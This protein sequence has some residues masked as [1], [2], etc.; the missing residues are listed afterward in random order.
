MVEFV[1]VC[2]LIAYILDSLLVFS[3]LFYTSK[4]ESWSEKVRN[5]NL[6][7]KSMFIL[8]EAIPPICQLS[9]LIYGHRHATGYTVL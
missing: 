9:S 4:L 7:K 5:V 8:S 1:V 3:L 6:K 2:F